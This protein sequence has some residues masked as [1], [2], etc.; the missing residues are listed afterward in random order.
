MGMMDQSKPLPVNSLVRNNALHISN[1]QIGQESILCKTTKG[2]LRWTTEFV[3]NVLPE[4]SLEEPEAVPS[5]EFPTNIEAFN[6]ADSHTEV[7]SW[8]NLADVKKCSQ[9][10]FQTYDRQETQRVS[11]LHQDRVIPIRIPRCQLLL[12]ARHP[13]HEVICSRSFK[14]RL[15]IT[16]ENYKSAQE[17]QTLS[18]EY[19]NR[20]ITLD[21][22]KSPGTTFVTEHLMVA[23][24]DFVP[25][26][27]LDMPTQVTIHGKNYS[28]LIYVDFVVTI[29]VEAGF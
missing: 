27:C 9:G 22:L 13:H 10:S 2:R 21:H 5:Y 16:L 19:N 29:D 7:I 15:P 4:E 28:P 24:P 11:I 8:I 23:F 26:A 14:G 3:F 12:T 18:L 17:N 6:C 25:A 20:T 1:I